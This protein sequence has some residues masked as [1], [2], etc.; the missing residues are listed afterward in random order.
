VCCG[1]MEWVVL[2][3]SQAG[4]SC[5]GTCIVRGE[6]LGTPHTSRLQPEVGYY[7]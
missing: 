4:Q 2:V 6:G 5:V 1:G 3:Y 7:T